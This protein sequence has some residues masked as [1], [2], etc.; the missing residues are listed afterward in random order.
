MSEKNISL[1]NLR[2]LPRPTQDTW[3]YSNIN[4]KDYNRKWNFNLKR[5]QMT[6]DVIKRSEG[7][8]D[9]ILKSPDSI[10]IGVGEK[11]LKKNFLLKIFNDIE[12]HKINLGSHEIYYQPNYK[13]ILSNY[14]NSRNGIKLQGLKELYSYILQL[15]LI[16]QNVK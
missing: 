6:P 10:I 12:F 1:I 14:F 5:H 7:I 8:K 2:P 4:K 13:I 11:E 3:A 15:N 16:S 9:F